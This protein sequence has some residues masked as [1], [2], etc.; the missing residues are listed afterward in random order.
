[1]PAHMAFDQTAAGTRDA[2]VTLFAQ[3]V[4]RLWLGARGLE[5]KNC[6]AVLHEVQPIASN[7]L[8]I[9]DIGLEQV[10]LA[11][12]TRQQSLLVVHLLLQVVD[13]DAAL[14]QLFVR[15]HEQTHNYKPHRNHQQNEKNSV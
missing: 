11:S 9:C 10:Y 6:F 12:L 15:R 14:H 4:G 3:R 1:M 7:C 8:E 2:C 13:L 5:A